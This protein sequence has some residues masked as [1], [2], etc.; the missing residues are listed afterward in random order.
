M[1]PVSTSFLSSEK[2]Q[3]NT[4]KAKVQLILGNYA[5]NYLGT[6]SASS[7]YSSDYPA[8][9]A[10]NGDRT[11]LNIGAAIS[12]DDGV[13]KSCWQSSAHPTGGSP[14]YITFSFDTR[15]TVSLSRMKLYH[16]PGHGLLSYEL[17]AYY[18]GTWNNV[19]HTDDISE[20]GV[21][22]TTNGSLDVV[23][24]PMISGVSEIRVYVYGTQNGGENAFISEIEFYN[25]VDISSYVTSVK[26]NR[27]R[28]YSMKNPLSADVE[29]VCDNRLSYFSPALS[30]IGTDM[31][32]NL[33]IMV[34]FGFDGSEWAYSFVGF[35]DELTISPSQRTATIVGRDGMKFVINTTKYSQLLSSYYVEDI[36]SYLV[37]QADVAPQEYVSNPSAVQIPYFFVDS[38]NVLMTIQDLV[39][40]CGDASFYFDENGL[41]NFAY[42]TGATPEN[43]IITTQSDWESADY[44]QNVAT[45]LDVDQLEGDLVAIDRFTD[46]NLTSNPVWTVFKNSAVNDPSASTFQLTWDSTGTG[47]GNYIDIHT[48]LSSLPNFGTWQADIMLPD[49]AAK[50]HMRFVCLNNTNQDGWYLE[51]TY[52]SIKF[53]HANVSSV[54]ASGS[55][56]NGVYHTLCVTTD[57]SG[58]V[59]VYVDGVLKITTTGYVAVVYDYFLIKFYG[60]GGTGTYQARKIGYFRSINSSGSVGG[61]YGGQWY[62]KFD[63]T[64]DV[65]FYGVFRASYVLN[66]GSVHFYASS[67]P[68]NTT[69]TGEYEIFDDTVIPAALTVQRYLKIR[70]WIRPL[71]L[72]RSD[73][74]PNLDLNNCNT[75]T[76]V[77]TDF[78]VNYSIGTGKAKY[79]LLPQYSFSYDSLL[80]DMEEKVTDNIGGANQIVNDCLVTSNPLAL[81]AYSQLVWQGTVGSPP[82]SISVTAPM[83][84]TNGQILTYQ[85]KPSS[86]MDISQMSGANP[87][88]AQITFAAGASGSWAFTRINPTNPILQ[89]TITGSGTMTNLQVW[90]K[91]FE[92]GS[93]AYSHQITDPDSIQLY[94]DRQLSIDNNYIVVDAMALLIAQTIVSNYKNAIT[95]LSKFVVRPTFSIQIGDRITATEINTGLASDFYVVGV[96]HT[97]SLSQLETELTLLKVA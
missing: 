59:N 34:Q 14:Q 11:S 28:D 97:F 60:Y 92:G 1:L 83:T 48:S 77:V 85:I 37:Q 42:Y 73:I 22:F 47:A 21:S 40:A 58:N 41:A 79:N 81:S 30:P 95:Y 44:R 61:Y 8:S 13:G 93:Y 19:A 69:F 27:Q 45:N 86:A 29:I 2:S 7:T 90:G 64:T 4:P 75:T 66:G 49:N 54:T 56:T 87:A 3:V 68:D 94:G 16:L 53:T 35:M 50:A 70:I 82:V 74:D 67:S 91:I 62:K 78:T 9:G 36:V 12:S 72:T 18:G 25:I 43:F 38:Q 32:P 51:F 39:V 65:S 26:V 17:I 33:G 76:P 55:W 46:G 23:D 6:A 52:N 63:C 96:Q 15:G 10:F 71:M 5:L 20:S 57:A 89:I 24:F 88:A 80:L 31:V 84:V